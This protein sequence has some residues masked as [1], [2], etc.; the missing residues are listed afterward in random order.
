M[1]QVNPSR[2]VESWL[3]VTWA[4]P[5]GPN[6]KKLL[7]GLGPVEANLYLFIYFGYKAGANL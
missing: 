2:P 3:V 7:D 1:V 5:L 6:V 4:F